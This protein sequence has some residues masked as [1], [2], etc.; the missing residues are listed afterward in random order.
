MGQK[1]IIQELTNIQGEDMVD[2]SNIKCSICQDLHFVHPGNTDFSRI[3]PC[4]CVETEY[5]IKK[6]Q[7]MIK[8]CEFPPMANA[9]SFDNY[10]AYSPSLQKFLNTCK[11]IAEQPTLV[12]LTISGTNDTGKT[13]LAVSI[14]KEWV[15]AGIPAKYAFVPLLLDELRQGFGKDG[16]YDSRFNTFCTVPLLL[17]D[18]LGAEYNTGWVQ[19]KLETIIDYRYMNSLSLIVTTNKTLGELSQRIRSRL[20]RHPSS[21]MITPNAQEY[22]MYKAKL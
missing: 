9:Y 3:V 17:L 1:K 11:Q 19:E 15:K 2:L 5:A 20:M 16:D 21:I 12:W 4:K 8:Y 6:K 18:D 14:C 10:N 7:A 22:T 13:H